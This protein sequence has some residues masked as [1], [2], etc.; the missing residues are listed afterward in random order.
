M[1]GPPLEKNSRMKLRMETSENAS[2]LLQVAMVADLPNHLGKP[3]TYPF[4]RIF[5][6]REVVD[7]FFT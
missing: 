6:I 5:L 4:T 3:T 2:G 7:L 1:K